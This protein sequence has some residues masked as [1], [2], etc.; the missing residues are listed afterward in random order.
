MIPRI[1]HQIWIGDQPLP[2]KYIY[3]IEKVKKINPNY[4]HKLWGNEV[5]NLYPDD[6]F[7]NRYRKDPKNYKWAYICDR[8][9]LLIL[10]DY[11]GIYVDIDAEPIKS[12]DYVLNQLSEK[13]TYFAGVRPIG[14]DDNPMPLIDCTVIGSEPRSRMIDFLISL[15]VD[16]DWA[17]MGRGLSDKMWAELGPDIALFDYKY[18]YDTEITDKTIV[19]HDTEDNRLWSWCDG[20]P[21]HEEG[22]NWQ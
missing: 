7:L 17:W 20:R 16:V 9:R 22:N 13:H 5:F 8:L 18:F 4:E 1:I 12:F 19:L 6:P 21:Y 11:G 10:R 2:E 3:F 15:Y 14:Q